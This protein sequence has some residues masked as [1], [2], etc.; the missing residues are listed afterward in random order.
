MPDIFYDK[1]VE[2]DLTKSFSKNN[3]NVQSIIKLITEKC[4]K[5][6][7]NPPTSV[8]GIPKLL[9]DFKTD[10]RK[11]FKNVGLPKDIIDKIMFTVETL[12]PAIEIDSADLE[13]PSKFAGTI[14]SIPSNI[15]SVISTLTTFLTDFS[16]NQEQ[17]LDGSALS[18]FKLNTNGIGHAIDEN[19][20]DINFKK[21]YASINLNSAGALY[22]NSKND[23]SLN[24]DTAYQKS[25]S[26]NISV[27]PYIGYYGIHPGMG[28][29]IFTLSP[30]IGDVYPPDGL[31]V[32]KLGY[33]LNYS[34]SLSNNFKVSFSDKNVQNLIIYNTNTL[35]YECVKN[36]FINNHDIN[37]SQ[38]IGNYSI[39]RNYAD[40][41]SFG[42]TP[43][44]NILGTLNY[45]YLNPYIKN[46]NDGFSSSK[47]LNNTLKTGTDNTIHD[48][49]KI[50][51][52]NIENTKSA[53][54][55]PLIPI[56]VQKNNEINIDEGWEINWPKPIDPDQYPTVGQTYHI[57]TVLSNDQPTYYQNIHINNIHDDYYKKV[58]NIFTK[59]LSSSPDVM[60]IK[61]NIKA[62]KININEYTSGFIGGIDNEIFLPNGY[63]N[64]TKLAAI[65][66]IKSKITHWTVELLKFFKG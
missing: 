17:Y 18:L 28:F 42:D 49:G 8:F 65:Q 2:T 59:V 66:N 33:E 47:L 53:L 57:K 35:Q 43:F 56:Q 62:N 50:I 10:L 64:E 36:E 38:K 24:A 20:T 32:E 51:Y 60:T 6:Y 27:T 15:L 19:I 4:T 58:D 46:G 25:Y 14:L 34:E 55:N 41:N 54:P 21:N 7:L 31:T 9:Q 3:I 40:N 5:Y 1:S 39:S 23:F 61:K 44:W 45:K 63:I 16:K 29:G 13:A 37:Y 48:N 30:K 12:L 22:L 26:K 52:N 11:I